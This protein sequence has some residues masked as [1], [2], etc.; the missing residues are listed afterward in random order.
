MPYAMS[1]G[2]TYIHDM[3]YMENIF[4]GYAEISFCPVGLICHGKIFTYILK[5]ST[6]CPELF[7]ILQ[8][9]MPF[10]QQV[11]IALNIDN[12]DTI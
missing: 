10:R 12:V 11:S 9:F 5:M 4:T 7:P 1:Y 3:V 6:R 2:M 8:F